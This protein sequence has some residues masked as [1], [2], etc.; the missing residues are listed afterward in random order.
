M[1]PNRRECK[2]GNKRG[3]VH[4]LVLV[5]SRFMHVHILILRHSHQTAILRLYPY[6]T[7]WDHKKQIRKIMEP[8]QLNSK[9]ALEHLLIDSALFDL[10]CG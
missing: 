10:E 2:A 1:K 3:F 8:F 5:L 4:T 9:S 7:G 6:E